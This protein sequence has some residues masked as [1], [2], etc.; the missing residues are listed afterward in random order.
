MAIKRSAEVLPVS[1]QPEG[2]DR[3][4]QSSLVQV[5]DIGLSVLSSLL[6]NQQYLTNKVDNF[7]H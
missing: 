5:G 6:M 2:H 1:K 4:L 7:K 3:S